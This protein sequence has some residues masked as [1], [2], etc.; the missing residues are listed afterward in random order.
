MNCI[1]FWSIDWISNTYLI[2]QNSVCIQI[3]I[4]F[5]V[6]CIAM[7]KCLSNMIS[8]SNPHFPWQWLF[9]PYKEFCRYQRN[10]KIKG[11]ITSPCWNISSGEEIWKSRKWRKQLQWKRCL[12]SVSFGMYSAT[13]RRSSPSAQHPIR[14]TSLLCLTFPT[15]EA[16]VCS[17]SITATNQFICNKKRATLLPRKKCHIFKML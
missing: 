14:F 4:N 7:I 5:P 2:K 1:V 12:E 10:I 15:P 3:M 6:L 9:F 16:S 13:K 17:T 11:Q 8:N